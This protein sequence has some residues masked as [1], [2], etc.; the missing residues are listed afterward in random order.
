MPHHEHED[1]EDGNPDC[2]KTPE[3]EFANSVVILPTSLQL[4]VKVDVAEKMLGKKKV[5]KGAYQKRGGEEGSTQE[6]KFTV[7]FARLLFL[8]DTLNFPDIKNLRAVEKG[9][10]Q[11]VLVQ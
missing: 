3:G 4:V 2:D 7:S 5:R 6:E 8:D 11:G 1:N 10:K 9:A